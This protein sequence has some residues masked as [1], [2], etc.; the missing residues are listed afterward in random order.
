MKK[1]RIV[2][3]Y[4]VPKGDISPDIFKLSCVMGADKND[5]GVTYICCINFND[6]TANDYDIHDAS[7]T[8]WIC[9]DSKGK[10]HVMHDDEY[11]K[12]CNDTPKEYQPIR[13]C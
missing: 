13:G 8:D 9:K 2:E 5:D 11:R 1:L 6:D 7:P 10:W 4:Q 12:I 3:A